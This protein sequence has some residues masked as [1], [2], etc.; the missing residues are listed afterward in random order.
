MPD[1]QDYL[2]GATRVHIIV[3]DPI[4]QVK[5]PSG[6]TQAF[7]DRGHNAIVMPAHVAPADLAACVQGLTRVQNVDG[8]IVTVPHKFAT[9]GLC[10]TASERAH[11]L[12]A[13]NTMRRNADGTWP[14]SYTH[15]TLPTILLV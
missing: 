6:V 13:T 8:I 1:I 10:T 9:Y 5:S 4:A 14:V 3:G 7:H 15:L 12:Q 2:D 11:F